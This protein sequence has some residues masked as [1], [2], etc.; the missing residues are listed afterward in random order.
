MSHVTAVFTYLIC[1]N[2]AKNFGRR[3]SWGIKS[4]DSADSVRRPVMRRDAC[5]DCPPSHS[6]EGARIQILIFDWTVCVTGVGPNNWTR[7]GTIVMAYIP[8][9]RLIWQLCICSGSFLLLVNFF[10]RTPCRH[11]V[12]LDTIL[13]AT[14]CS[15][16]CVPGS[17]PS[18]AEKL[19]AP[20]KTYKFD[21]RCTNLNQHLDQSA[22][23]I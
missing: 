11:L 5:R 13:N 15:T 19:T 23:L 18:G 1:C 4:T 17:T 8:F 2:P 20:G 22:R 10:P 3:G 9:Q 6:R 21:C 12:K 14:I 16:E 7:N